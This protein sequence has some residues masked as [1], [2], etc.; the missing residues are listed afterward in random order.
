MLFS[1]E[2]GKKV[3]LKRKQQQLLA[4][5][6]SKALT[7]RCCMLQR[8]VGSVVI[9]SN[10]C[11]AQEVSDELKTLSQPEFYVHAGGG[12]GVENVIVATTQRLANREGMREG[13]NPAQIISSNQ[14]HVNIT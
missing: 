4:K 5:S 13:L 8:L 10:S 1:S 6:L 14:Q 9:G 2:Q 7:C 3:A 12:G 11:P